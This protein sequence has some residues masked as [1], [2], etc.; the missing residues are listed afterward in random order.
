MW[1]QPPVFAAE[2]PGF[3]RF[4]A[5]ASPASADFGCRSFWDFSRSRLVIIYVPILHN[6]P[7]LPLILRENRR[8]VRHRRQSHTSKNGQNRAERF[9]VGGDGDA[10]KLRHS[11]QISPQRVGGDGEHGGFHN[12]ADTTD[13]VPTIQ[14]LTPTPTA[15]SPWDVEGS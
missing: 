3:D 5:V 11:P 7:I 10:A 15:D 6:L 4:S 2:M 13:R 12:P 1:K 9:P 14:N 8:N